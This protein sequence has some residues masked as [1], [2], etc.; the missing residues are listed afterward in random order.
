MQ[1][2]PGPFHSMCL[3]ENGRLFTFGNSKDGKLGI[4]KAKGVNEI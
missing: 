1:I 4:I 2:A 3:D